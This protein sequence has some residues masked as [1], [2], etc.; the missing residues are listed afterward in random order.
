MS[1]GTAEGKGTWEEILLNATTR[2]KKTSH[3]AKLKLYLYFYPNIYL[4]NKLTQM[5][6]I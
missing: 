3:I 1:H 5:F 2:R 4:E 6:K